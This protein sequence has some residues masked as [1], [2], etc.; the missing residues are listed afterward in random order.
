MPDTRSPRAPDDL[1]ELGRI[2]AAY[3]VKGWVKVQPYSAHAEVLLNTAS[4]W[5]KAPVPLAGA[6]ALSHPA[7]VEVL[8]CRLHG[9]SLAASLKGVADRS[10]AESL[11][12]YGVWV[13]RAVFPS[14]EPDE[15][16][17]VDLIGCRLWGLRDNAPEPIGCVTDVVDNGA[18][19]ILRVARA[20]PEAVDG[21]APAAGRARVDEVLV[22]FVAA[23]IRHVD[24]TAR[25]IDSD[26]PVDF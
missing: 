10:Q 13:S 9:A 26:W 18:H 24:L 12:G 23:H 1:I 14:S 5:L 15:Y 2:A 8:A 3:G 25:R 21:A 7:P 20:A 17:W 19:A 22:P 6:G 16:Y 4:W 11:K